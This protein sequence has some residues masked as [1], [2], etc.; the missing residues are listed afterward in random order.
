[1]V[2]INA[3]C[4]GACGPM[5]ARMVGS[6]SAHMCCGPEVNNARRNKLPVENGFGVMSKGMRHKL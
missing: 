3:S 6:E 1:M 2:H 5:W 4:A